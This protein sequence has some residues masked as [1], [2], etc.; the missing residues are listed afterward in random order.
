MKACSWK[1]RHNV[2]VCKE[3]RPSQVVNLAARGCA[4]LWQFKIAHS[5][6]SLCEKSTG[7]SHK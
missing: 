4:F 2:A 3:S 1:A 5:L 6:L 7:P